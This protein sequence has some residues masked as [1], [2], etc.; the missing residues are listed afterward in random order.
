LQNDA[1]MS[2]A[3]AEPMNR[4]STVTAATDRAPD[5]ARQLARDAIAGI[6]RWLSIRK[7]DRDFEKFLRLY[8][9]RPFAEFYAWQIDRKL[10]RGLAHRTLGNRIFDRGRPHSIAAEHDNDSFAVAHSSLVARV[11]ET[12]LSPHHTLVEFGCGSL[13][14]GQHFIRLL[15]SGNY[16]G[17]D[18]TDRFYSDGLALLDRNLLREK[19][20]RCRVISLSTLAEIAIT[21]PDFIVSVA[22]LKHVPENELAIYFGRIASLMHS[23]TQLAFDYWEADDEHRMAGKSWAYT[24]GR[25]ARLLKEH[26]PGRPVD[27]SDIRP[28]R[29]SSSAKTAHRVALVGPRD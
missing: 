13:R 12:G 25:I 11:I 2:I 22:V 6:R 1:L 10:N 9:D 26:C 16:C 14:I 24:G 28:G 20:P 4:S 3:R 8:P 21:R 15:E 7:A 5:R 29:S 23:H 17:L 27:V 19:R 18:I